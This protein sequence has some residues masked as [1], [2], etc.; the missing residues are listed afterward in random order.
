MISDEEDDTSPRPGMVMEDEHC[1][2]Q[3][4]INTPADKRRQNNRNIVCDLD[5]HS[6]VTVD[7]T[8]PCRHLV[9]LDTKVNPG[10]MQLITDESKKAGLHSTSYCGRPLGHS[11]ARDSEQDTLVSSIEA[12]ADASNINAVTTQSGRHSVRSW[13]TQ[14]GASHGTAEA[15]LP[16]TGDC[17]RKLGLSE[18]HDS[19]RDIYFCSSD[20]AVVAGSPRTGDCGNQLGFSEVTEGSSSGIV[21]ASSPRART[22]ACGKQL[23]ISESSDSDRDTGIYFCNSEAAA[24]ASTNGAGTTLSG[25]QQVRSWRTQPGA[26]QSSAEAGS[27]RT[28]DC[29]IKAP[30][31]P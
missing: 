6:C 1:E 22:R 5:P 29:D 8:I 10:G 13:R 16:R 12:A 26:S 27:P 21:V 23:R 19:D 7:V 2:H 14:P 11:E 28:G 15:G 31:Y 18:T 30:G 4:H 20:S 3:H 17:G 24:E 25:R 9:N